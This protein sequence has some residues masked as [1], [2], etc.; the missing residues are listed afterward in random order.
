MECS[1]NNLVVLLRK[2]KVPKAGPRVVFRRSMKTFC[3]ES[4]IEDVNNICWDYVLEKDNPDDAL[5][6]FN[7]LFM[8][9]IEKHT[10]LRKQT[11]RN[12]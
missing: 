1:D 10:P 8:Q 9:V 11:V 2:T 5:E 4:F 6:V 7:V 3:E 12:L